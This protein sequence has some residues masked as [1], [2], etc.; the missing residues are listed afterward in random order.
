MFVFNNQYDPGKRDPSTKGAISLMLDVS[1]LSLTF[2][3]I[4]YWEIDPMSDV[5][6]VNGVDLN[7]QTRVNVGG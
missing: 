6:I 2:A 7:A 5:C 4:K 1:Y 3:D